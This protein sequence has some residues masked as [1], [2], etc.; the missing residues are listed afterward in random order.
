MTEI[1]NLKSDN[2]LLA[3]KRKRKLNIIFSIIALVG[4][5]LVLLSLFV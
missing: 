2:H 1:V 4:L 5:V 3:D